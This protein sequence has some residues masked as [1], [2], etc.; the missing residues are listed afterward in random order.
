MPVTAISRDTIPDQ[1]VRR[2]VKITSL[3]P[4]LRDEHLVELLSICIQDRAAFCIDNFDFL[5]VFVE[6]KLFR[7]PKSKV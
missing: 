7:C 1:A 6:G 5:T 4:F 3:R 2:E